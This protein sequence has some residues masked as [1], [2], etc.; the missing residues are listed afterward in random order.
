MTDKA[1]PTPI[2]VSKIRRPEALY[3]TRVPLE[4]LATRDPCGPELVSMPF[5][6]R[7]I[8]SHFFSDST[9]TCL[10]ALV[11]RTPRLVP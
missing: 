2:E 11:N 1:S 10:S 3:D 8:R 6:S 5:H 9:S 4:V 7:E